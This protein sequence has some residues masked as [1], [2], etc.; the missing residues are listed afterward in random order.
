MSHD[1]NHAFF[2][3]GGT[4]AP[5]VKATETPRAEWKDDFARMKDQGF[6]AVRGWT[7]WD[8]IERTEGERDFGALDA[9]LELAEKYGLRV[10]LNVGGV[11]DNLAGLYPPRWLLRDYS[12]QHPVENPQIRERPIGARRRVC[13]DDPVYREKAQ[14]FI[15]HVVRHCA[16]SRALFAWGVWNEPHWNGCYC[17]HTQSGFIAWLKGKYDYLGALNDSWS[18]EFPVDFREWEEIE[19][20]SG[21]GF[22]DGGYSSWLDW[23]RFCEDDLTERIASVNT[24]VRENDPAGR[25][26]TLNLTPADISGSALGRH[27]DLESV[28]KTVD[29]VGYSHYTYRITEP[30]LMA[31]KLDRIRCTTPTDDLWI[32]ETESGPVFWVHGNLPGHTPIDDRLL[33]YRQAVAHNTSSIFYWL[34]RTRFTDAQA[35]EFGLTAWDGSPTER[36][37]RTGELSAYLQK[38]VDAFT[39]RHARAQ[40]AILV[41]QSTLRLG[42]AEGYEGQKDS[43]K[44]YW[45]RSWIGAY[46]LMWDL[47][48][49]V[50][51]VDGDSVSAEALSEYC[52]VLIPFHPNVSQRLSDVLISYARQGGLVVAECFF[53]FK[54]DRGILQPKAPGKELT[55]IFGAYTVDAFPAQ[56]ETIHIDDLESI[57]TYIF[58]QSFQMVAGDSKT[59]STIIGTYDSGE[60]AIVSNDFGKGRGVLVGTLLYAAYSEQSDISLRR[61]IAT[62]LDRT[63]VR[64]PVRVDPLHAA[65][66]SDTDIVADIDA[67]ETRLLH[68]DGDESSPLMMIINHGSE[69][70]IARFTLPGIEEK[71]HEIRDLSEKNRIDVL[72]VDGTAAFE[73]E[74]AAKS[75]LD[76]AI[77]CK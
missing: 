53:G 3:F 12:C 47:R 18:T 8:R 43:N 40:T 37:L 66:V 26:T 71:I 36:S 20:P 4:Y 77:L 58:K 75:A 10:M 34:Y 38:H 9:L 35:G 33:R 52:A 45:E 55:E 76:L 54:D 50:D 11:F 48:I 30:H 24:I 59:G 51:F 74:L 17:P 7:P 5:V 57:S 23:Q 22:L 69:P 62:L 27:V 67:I 29:V 65:D 28:A 41:S 16:Q 73:L 21:V 44:N 25:P 64:P 63:G 72:D 60:A 42:A 14:T 1:N 39:G 32:I 61:L 19:P 31:A 68:G 49:P 56:G 15:E 46:K 6:T 13:F 70:V 2:A